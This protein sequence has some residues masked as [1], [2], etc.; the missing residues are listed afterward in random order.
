LSL[1]YSPSLFATQAG[2]EKYRK[3]S[4]R[5][6]PRTICTLIRGSTCISHYGTSFIVF[7]PQQGDQPLFSYKRVSIYK[8]S[9]SQSNADANSS[10]PATRIKTSPTFPRSYTNNLLARAGLSSRICLAYLH[11][12]HEVRD[13]EQPGHIAS[14]AA[15]NY[16]LLD[17]R[18]IPT[19]SKDNQCQH[20]HPTSSHAAAI[21]QKK[22]GVPMKPALSSI[23]CNYR[24]DYPD[25]LMFHRC[26]PSFLLA[27]QLK[28]VRRE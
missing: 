17:A 23:S 22:F 12:R 10:V 27:L 18:D 8:P 16:V 7:C 28:A 13:L 4:F 21:S 14:A 26:L 5:L 15:Q 24:D 11:S 1:D 25:G 6:R 19:T 3:R 20:T 2:L 9:F